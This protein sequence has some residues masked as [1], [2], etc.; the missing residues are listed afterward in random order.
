MATRE[1]SM[2]DR[3]PAVLAA[4]F[5]LVVGLALAGCSGG[6]SGRGAN[7]AASPA[8]RAASGSTPA[9]SES[10]GTTVPGTSSGRSGGP[11]TVDATFTGAVAGHFDNPTK[12]PKYACGTPT[13]PDLFTL[14]DV[15][16]TVGGA[17]YAL[18]ISINNFTPA[19]PQ[20]GNT[21]LSLTPGADTAHGFMTVH[22]PTVVM[23]DKQSGTFEGDL[24]QGLDAGAPVMHVKGSFHC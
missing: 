1:H 13:F 17:T 24:Q 15:D 5:A 10:G 8:G 14:N 20:H 3:I 21:V 19:G 2:N 9:R 12:G 7:G 22:P 16:G 4:A 23:A 18:Q 6:V 11:A